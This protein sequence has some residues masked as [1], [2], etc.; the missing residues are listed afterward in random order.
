MY[1]AKIST[2][3]FYRNKNLIFSEV[4][5]NIIVE[6]ELHTLDVYMTFQSFEG[7][8]QQAIRIELIRNKKW[9]LRPCFHLLHQHYWYH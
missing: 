5:F 4:V 1:E 7:V 3:D 2:L 9:S 6:I 8:I